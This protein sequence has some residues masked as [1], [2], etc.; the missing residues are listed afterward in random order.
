[1]LLRASA[2]ETSVAYATIW[3]FFM[4]ELGRLPYM[5]QMATSLTEDHKMRRESFANNVYGS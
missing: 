5:L 3:N 4:K 2:A 1:M